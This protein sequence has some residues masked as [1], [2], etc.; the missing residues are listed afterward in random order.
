MKSNNH[1]G[2]ARLQALQQLHIGC[3]RWCLLVVE[4]AALDPIYARRS[5]SKL[6]K[7][8]ADTLSGGQMPV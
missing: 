2:K 7:V 3:K 6:M 5:R 1:L 8:L 4:Q